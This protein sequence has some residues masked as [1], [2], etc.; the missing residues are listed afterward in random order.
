M[1]DSEDLKDFEPVDTLPSK[2][3]SE[4]FDSFFPKRT[5]ATAFSPKE[6]FNWTLIIVLIFIFMVLTF[7]LFSTWI[8]K[9]VDV[10]KNVI[11]VGEV[12]IFSIALVV[13]LKIVKR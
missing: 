5:L 9:K 8:R 7:P 3:E 13:T 11:W 2:K 6:T 12:A 10:D 4:F 1:G